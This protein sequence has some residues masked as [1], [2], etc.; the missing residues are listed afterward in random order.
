MPI[1]TIL[2][3]AVC[4]GGWKLYEQNQNK[5]AAANIVR[6]EAE[7]AQLDSKKGVTLFT[8]TWCGYCTKLKARL[9]AGNVPY[10]DYDIEHSP[11]GK[12]Y[13]DSAKFEGVPIM[14]V[15]GTTVEG[16]DM[17]KMPA[18]FADAGY[19]VSGL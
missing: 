17:N 4:F 13:F 15:N 9:D 2:L 6:Y 8:A 10:V 12:M 5:I 16:Y 11:Q 18:L 3:L 7:L 14:V 1:K 19:E